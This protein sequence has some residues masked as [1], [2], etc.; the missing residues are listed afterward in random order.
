MPALALGG[1]SY[2]KPAEPVEQPVGLTLD[3]PRVTLE[4][5]GSGERRVLTFQDID[6]E[7]KLD[8]SVTQG[9]SQDLLKDSAAKDFKAGDVD[10][11]TTTLPLDAS[12][13]KA[14][15]D[16]EGQLPATRNGFVTAGLPTYS[17][18][19]QVDSAEG[20]QFGW[21]A[22]DNGQMNSLRLAAPQA[23]TDEARGVVEQAI[24]K[25]TSLPIVFPKEEV[26][27]GATWTVESRVA[28]ES[29]L[30]QTTTYT[31]EKLEG[32]VLTLGVKVAQRP[33]LGA[34][35]FEGQAQG[36]ELE[37]KELEVMGTVTD[38]TGT[39]TVDL[40]KPL[41]TGGEVSFDTK[42]IYGTEGSDLRVV[43]STSTEMS[44]KPAG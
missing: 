29:T 36:T 18:S 10:S 23:A 32:D 25:L 7:Q 41:P 40:S 31:L 14:T 21:R 42:I 44:F 17:G 11:A 30:L 3:A 22:T 19:A 2:E 5:A 35:S 39:L 24:M 16:V 33:S 15:E 20:F 37:D 43:Q 34:L 12:V 26:G 27:Q 9:F 6:A 13:E 1:C 38:S 4:D 8:Y 28:G